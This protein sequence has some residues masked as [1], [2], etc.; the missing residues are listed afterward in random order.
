MALANVGIGLDKAKSSWLVKDGDVAGTNSQADEGA[1]Q[2]RFRQSAA[3]TARI[4]NGGRLPGFLYIASSCYTSYSIMAHTAVW[5]GIGLLSQ[6]FC[7]MSKCC[8]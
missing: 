4:A 2:R 3:P 7:V 1:L 5:S 8:L 6:R